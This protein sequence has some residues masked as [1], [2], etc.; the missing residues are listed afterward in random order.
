MA[1]SRRNYETHIFQFI[2]TRASDSSTHATTVDFLQ[3]RYPFFQDVH[4][5]IFVGFGFL[6]VLYREFY[7]FSSFPSI[8]CVMAHYP[9]YF[10]SLL[11]AHEL[12]FHRS[13]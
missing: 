9:L 11:V 3:S 13:S 7:R 1:M 10:L 12:I 8:P 4:V 2:R 5:M 6:M